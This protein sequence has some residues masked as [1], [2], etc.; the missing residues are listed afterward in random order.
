MML[1]PGAGP[2][3][4]CCG[5][6]PKGWA[7]VALVEDEPMFSEPVIAP[8]ASRACVASVWQA[9]SPGGEELF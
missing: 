9:E 6:R 8:E 1:R 4:G 5:G 3:L 2:R 7:L